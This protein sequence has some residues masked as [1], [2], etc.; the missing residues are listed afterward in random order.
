MGTFY[1]WK[2]KYRGEAGAEQVGFCKIVP[3]QEKEG[4]TLQ[5]PSGLRLQ[6]SGLPLPELAELILTLDR[7]YA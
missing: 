2:K 3:K 7:A 1:A 6:I 5:L 4:A